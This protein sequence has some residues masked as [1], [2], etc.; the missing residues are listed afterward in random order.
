MESKEVMVFL[1]QK[2]YDELI[3]AQVK[4]TILLNLALANEYSPSKKRINCNP[5]E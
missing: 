4:N 5:W 2:K 3:A 1:T